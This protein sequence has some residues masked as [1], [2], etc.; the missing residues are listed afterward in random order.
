MRPEIDFLH[1]QNV[2]LGEYLEVDALDEFVVVLGQVVENDDD[3][4]LNENEQTVAV[5]HDETDELECTDIDEDD[6]V[7]D[8]QNDNEQ[9]DDETLEIADVTEQIIDDE[10]DDDYSVEETDASE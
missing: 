8:L 6:E 7:I 5:Q 4:A 9:V 10:V 2:M 3:E 1:L